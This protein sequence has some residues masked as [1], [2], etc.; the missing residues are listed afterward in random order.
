[1]NQYVLFGILA[2]AAV[3]I[4]FIIL[5]IVVYFVSSIPKWLYVLVI[6]GAVFGVAFIFF[7]R[8]VIQA[9]GF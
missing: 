6:L 8:T 1:M 5:R 7:G 9:F 4:A 2:F 3:V